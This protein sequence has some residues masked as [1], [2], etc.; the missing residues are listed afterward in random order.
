MGKQLWLAIVIAGSLWAA[1]A[2]AHEDGPHAAL[3]ADVGD[4]PEVAGVLGERAL[5]VG[6]L[7]ANPRGRNR[8]TGISSDCFPGTETRRSPP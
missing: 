3:L 1:P 5:E 2:A 4:A 6:E 8:L 7:R